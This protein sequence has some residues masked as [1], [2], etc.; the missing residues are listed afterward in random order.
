MVVHSGLNAVDL[1]SNCLVPGIW[2]DG[3]VEGG[4]Q[5]VLCIGGVAAALNV[6]PLEVQDA[7]WVAYGHYYHL[8]DTDGNL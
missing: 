3:E 1:A 4:K 8:Q 7:C 6:L 5:G 2:Q